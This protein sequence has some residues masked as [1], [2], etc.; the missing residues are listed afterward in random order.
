MRENNHDNDLNCSD[1]AVDRTFVEAS[2]IA[3]LDHGR[4]LL[5]IHASLKAVQDRI[6][7][8]YNHI[9]TDMPEINKRIHLTFQQA[10]DTLDTLSITGS[11]GGID[12]T[13]ERL[14]A[15][16]Q[17][18]VLQNDRMRDFTA[19]SL[20]ALEIIE[21]HV[22]T[23]FS[24][25]QNSSL[26][27]IQAV[28]SD[29]A[30]RCFAFTAAI[31]DLKEIT[32]KSL[33]LQ[34]EYREK[35][36]RGKNHT[37]PSLVCSLNSVITI[38][39]DLISRS[40]SV[41][42]P[43]L[44]IMSG[45]QTHDIVNQDI[46]TITCGLK[47]IL[48]LNNVIDEKDEIMDF[49]LFQEKTS[50]L[51]LD[52]IVRLASVIRIH[53][54]ELEN[55]IGRIENMVCHVKEDKEAL[56]EFLLL[57]TDSKT[58][59]DFVS[60]EITGML[61]GLASDYESLAA[62]DSSC[63]AAF[64]KMESMFHDLDNVEKNPACEAA[65]RAIH[66]SI[67]VLSSL[68]R[69]QDRMMGDGTDAAV[70]CNISGEFR[71]CLEFSRH[72]FRNIRNLLIESIGGIDMCSIRCLHAIENFRQ[73]IGDLM[74]TLEGSEIILDDLKN[75]NQCI[76]A[77]RMDISEHLSDHNHEIF[78]P[79]FDEIIYRLKNPHSDSLLPGDGAETRKSD[80]TFF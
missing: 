61:E 43:I 22:P 58:T 42:D 8:A 9:S 5:R 59:F 47:K 52:L 63:Q 50:L 18:L 3:A 2:H 64:S 46:T 10:M 16:L 68:M 17:M 29:R 65:L 23:V 72:S 75:F 76:A 13:A 67:S 53:G 36:D 77:V 27:A 66:D 4:T 56:S 60:C 54:R 26:Q 28:D 14:R 74:K 49:L 73:D 19:R 40:G 78:S 51:S 48:T 15:F 55:E 70:C 6:D 62:M 33:L 45:L 21:R 38:L 39:R 32:T 37:L 79:E 35:I 80:L 44:K 31:D 1:A 69:A 71:K 24:P 25:F 57:S 41:K 20:E 12:M 7:R 34:S 30:D 11:D